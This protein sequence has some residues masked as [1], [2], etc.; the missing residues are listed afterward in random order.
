MTSPILGDQRKVIIDETHPE[1]FIGNNRIISK[2]VN[3]FN[4]L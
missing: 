4:T 2:R 3:Q 1:T